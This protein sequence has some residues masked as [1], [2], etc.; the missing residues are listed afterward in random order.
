MKKESSL[1][2]KFSMTFNKNKLLEVLQKH[3]GAYEVGI[4]CGITA[5]RDL[6]LPDNVINVV[7]LL[8]SLLDDFSIALEKDDWFLFVIGVIEGLS[9]YG[10]SKDYMLAWE[11][12]EDEMEL[13]DQ[14]KYIVQWF[15]GKD[16]YGLCLTVLGD[17]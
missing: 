10:F 3:L 7:S 1:S 5:G 2:Y 12:I 8:K 13:P 14:S 11:K 17:D 6:I 4:L 16:W 15:D 9:N